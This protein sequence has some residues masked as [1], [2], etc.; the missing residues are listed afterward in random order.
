MEKKY[1]SLDFEKIDRWIRNG[2]HGK[3]RNALLSIRPG[4]V[5]RDHLVT[6]AD[7]GRRVRDPMYSLKTL[8]KV[9]RAHLEKAEQATS[10]E[11]IAYCKA[12]G[13]MGLFEE[14]NRW[15]SLLDPESHKEIH[16]VQGRMFMVQ[17]NYS[18]AKTSFKKYLKT[19]REDDYLA[20]VTKLNLSA[21]LIGNGDCGEAQEV[22][23]EL[24][25]RANTGGHK[26][27]QANSLELLAQANILTGNHKEGLEYLEKSLATLGNPSSVYHFYAQKWMWISEWLQRGPE[28]QALI[29]KVRGLIQHARENMYFEDVRD[30]E[31]RLYS[32]LQDKQGLTHLLFGTVH[33][34]YRKRVREAFQGSE[35]F[36]R[37]YQW[38]LGQGARRMKVGREQ[39]ADTNG[40]VPSCF[41]ILSMD[42]YRPISLGFLFSK[43]YPEEY[44]DPHHSPARVYRNICRL[45]KAFPE[46]SGLEIESSSE[47]YQLICTGAV[48]IPVQINREPVSR[49]QQQVVNLRGIVERRWFTTGEVAD[50]MKVSQRTAQEILKKAKKTYRL[51]TAGQG[52]A[53]R[54]RFAG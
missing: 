53:T 40:L 43:L 17:W 27:I 34:S 25:E 8:G 7:F 22:L 36:P 30:L 14:A 32:G 4:D 10:L 49:D 21:S 1:S 24:Y 6:L 29:E 48:E 37:S 54:Y 16:D 41:Q 28:D 33:D 44:F 50:E 2:E 5:S 39:L 38:K 15:L 52:R 51:E 13:K 46:G 23:N 3:A 9:M 42:F 18:S 47:G 35:G 19:L 20:K 11:I 45:R 12:L 31:L 26:L